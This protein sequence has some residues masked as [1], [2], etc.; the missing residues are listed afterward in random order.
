MDI[1][2]HQLALNTRRGAA[3]GFAGIAKLAG[4]DLGSHVGALVPKLYRY[5]YDPAPRVR[6]AM[7]HIW[8]ALVDDPKKAGG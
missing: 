4:A 1:A 3:F 5:Q 7:G 2:H 8:R 6:D